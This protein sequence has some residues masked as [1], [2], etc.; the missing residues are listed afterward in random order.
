M[1]Q[2]FRENP[3][4][5]KSLHMANKIL[6]GL[7]FIAYPCL[8]L[9]ML[10]HKDPRLTNAILYPMNGFICVTVVRAILNFP[11]PY[12]R[13]EMPPVIPKNTKGHSWPSRHVFS[14]TIIALIFFPVN[15]PLGT[16]LLVCAAGIAVIRPGIFRGGRPTAYLTGKAFSARVCVVVSFF[17]C[18]PLVSAQMSLPLWVII[19]ISG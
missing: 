12:E 7:V 11:R 6:T 15:M 9:W 10:W 8:L 2:P 4:L 14:A 16:V 19:R 18:S 5:A 3:K 17:R 13:F 1:T